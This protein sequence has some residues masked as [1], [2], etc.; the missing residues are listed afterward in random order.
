M[1]RAK[2]APVWR[3]NITVG[4]LNVQFPDTLLWKRRFMEVDEGGNIVLGPTRGDKVSSCS[5]R[6]LPPALRGF[7]G[8]TGS[9]PPRCL[10]FLAF[11]RTI[12]D[13]V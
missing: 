13:Q 12:A 6:L 4:E 9:H 5:Q 8:L 10:L 2:L 3:Q 7:D 1:L 11:S